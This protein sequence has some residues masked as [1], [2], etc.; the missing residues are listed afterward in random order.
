ML[1]ISKSMDQSVTLTDSNDGLLWAGLK[2]FWQGLKLWK[3]VGYL[4]WED[5]RQRYIRTFLGPLWLIIGTAIWA[6]AMSFV[7]ASLFGNSILQTLPF[8]A[9]GTILWNF[10]A[11]TMNDG[12]ILFINYTGIIHS[13][14]LPMSVHV[15][16]FLIRN[17]IIFLHNFVIFILV[18]LVCHVSFNMNTLLVIPGLFLLL[19]NAL[20]VGT[21]FGIMNTRYRDVQQI[22]TTSMSVLPFITPIFWE[23]SFLKK[24]VWI[25][26][27]N[28]FYHAIEIVRAPLLGQAAPM[29]SWEVMLVTGILGSLFTLVLY[30]KFRYRIIFW[31]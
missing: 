5:V 6:G 4:G 9:A 24:H 1:S 2:D 21:L 18:F 26:N 19:L 20:W 27:I 7:M 31:V 29:L 25:A 3:M 22:I 11:H 13:I 10:M 28:P 15:L 12:C 30:S 8:I 16:R 23:R 17:F 14:A